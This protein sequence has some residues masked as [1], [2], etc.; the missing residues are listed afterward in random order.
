MNMIYDARRRGGGPRPARG[1]RVDSTAAE[2]R[3]VF[4]VLIVDPTARTPP[5]TWL[6]CL[7]RRVAL[8]VRRPGLPVGRLQ[9]LTPELL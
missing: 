4:P 2:I 5:L 6:H 3:S 9:D 7:A 8:C 1:R